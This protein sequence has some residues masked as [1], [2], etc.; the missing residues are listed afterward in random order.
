M[1]DLWLLLF[2]LVI[3]LGSLKNVNQTLLQASSL[4]GQEERDSEHMPIPIMNHTRSY[5]LNI[6]WAPY[7]RGWQLHVEGTR[8]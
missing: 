7:K 1:T 6:G 5:A 4:G 2:V 3:E 8:A